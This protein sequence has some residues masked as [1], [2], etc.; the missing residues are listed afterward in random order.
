MNVSVII[1]TY[2]EE[3]YL[4]NLLDSISDQNYENYEVTLVDSGSADD[5]LEIASSFDFVKIVEIKKE[6]F[7]FGYSLNTGIENSDGD[8]CVM[9]SGHCIP[10]DDT[11]LQNIVESFEDNDV[12]IV[13]GN[14]HPVE[15]SE[16]SEKEIFR[17]RF[18]KDEKKQWN[19]PFC[20]N[21]NCAIR[22][23]VWERLGGYDE[24][25]S[26]LEDIV[27]AKKMLEETDKCVYY[28][29]KAGVYHIH[30][31]SW[32]QVKN[33]Y[34]REA[35]TYS[36]RIKLGETFS[37][38]DF[39]KLSFLSICYDLSSLFRNGGS[40]RDFYSIFLFRISQYWGTYK[41]FKFAKK[42]NKLRKKFYFPS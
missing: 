25:V 11:W 17:K 37:V 42:N 7:T 24:T 22:K 12:G 27:M 40:F 15:W 33:R 30:E 3:K 31:E 16:F 10:V 34:Y 21:A 29:P 13:Y 9:I 35:V 26:G 23:S 1:R 4:E 28:Q 38:W 32:S 6:N 5:T 41:G 19:D 20:N 2:N 36:S 18:S 39:L 14:Q 8:V